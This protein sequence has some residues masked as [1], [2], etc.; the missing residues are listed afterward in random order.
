MNV[1]NISLLRGLAALFVTIALLTM[2]T[3]CSRN[4]LIDQ[5]PQPLTQFIAQYFPG[6]GISQYEHTD[7]GYHIR[8]KNG[9]GMN[10]DSSY[11]W[12]N[13]DGYG[14]PLPQVF[15]FDQTPPKLYSYLQ[16]TSSLNQVFSIART[17]ESYSLTLLNS[18]LIYNISTEEISS[19]AN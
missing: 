13:I 3:S 12:E 5:V 9:P 4:E 18:S 8:L 17:S 19:P 1:R 6:Y 15:L 7:G 16:G 2:P 10:F 14:I 11:A